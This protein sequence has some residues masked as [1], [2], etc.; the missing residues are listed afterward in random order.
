MASKDKRNKANG[1]KGRKSQPKKSK[2]A[3]TPKQSRLAKAFMTAGSVTEAAIEAGY[4]K[5]YAG[6][7]GHAALK[8]IIRKGPE[9][10]EEAGLTLT[11][12]IEKRLKP[13]LDWN[14]TK[15]AQHEGKFTDYVTMPDGAI[16]L[17]AVDKAFRLLGAYPP[18]DPV[19]AAKSTV[20]VIIADMLRPRY[21]VE[22]VDVLPTVRPPRKEI[23]AQP[24]Q[25]AP[26][27]PT[28]GAKRDPRPKD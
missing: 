19:L 4:A 21:D 1:G 7:A 26:S 24:V 8:A 20:D 10:M 2:S 11:A 23:A 6:Q 22:P 25:A 9:A 13:L 18:E 27:T 16:R 17:G 28:N 15:W 14:V 12:V 5:K 3:L